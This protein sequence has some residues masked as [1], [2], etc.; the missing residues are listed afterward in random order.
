[1]TV[2]EFETAKAL[3]NDIEYLEQQ[4]R[5]IQQ[6]Y[7]LFVTE[8][9][10]VHTGLG[11]RKFTIPFELTVPCM[12]SIRDILEDRIKELKQRFAEL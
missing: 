12:N 4:L 11:H 1:M 6:D 5:T 8:Y 9:I 10:T 2:Q 3:L 7:G